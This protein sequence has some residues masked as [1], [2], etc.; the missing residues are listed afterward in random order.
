LSWAG[1]AFAFV[2]REAR[3]LDE[4]RFEEWVELFDADGLYWVPLRPGQTDGLEEMSIF[5]DDRDLLRA[6]LARLRHPAAHADTPAPRVVRG[7]SNLEVLAMTADE[8][9]LAGV[10]MMVTWREQ[11]QTLYAARVAWTLR[12]VGDGDYRIRLKRVDLVNCE[13]FHSYLTVPF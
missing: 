12:P 4:R 8:A 9:R 13:A 6:R 7:L 10:L 3:L 1:A 11:R 5:R 2:T